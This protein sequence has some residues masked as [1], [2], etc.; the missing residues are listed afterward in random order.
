MRKVI[1]QYY[2]TI[3]KHLQIIINYH[4]VNSVLFCFVLFNLK[5]VKISSRSGKWGNL[6]CPNFTKKKNIFFFLW[7]NIPI[8]WALLFNVFKNHSNI[9]R[10]VISLNTSQG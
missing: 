8:L 6:Q 2:F 1:S 3:L 10:R 9:F 7:N 5:G 4:F